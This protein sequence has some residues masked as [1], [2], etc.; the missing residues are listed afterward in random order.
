MTED[1]AKSKLTLSGKK[2]LTLKNLSDA[3][4]AGDGKK[5]V[6]VEVRKKRVINPAAPAGKEVKIDEATAAKLKLIAEAKEHEARRQQEE[7]EKAALR[8]KQKEEE[9]RLKE[10]EEQKRREEEERL[11]KEK[12]EK[13]RQAA[14]KEKGRTE[15]AEDE[16]DFKNK[17]KERRD[18]DFDD[19][20]D[21]DDRAKKARPTT[22]KGKSK[23]EV[24]E[25][26]RKKITKRSFEPQRRNP[27]VNIH[28][29]GGSDDDDD[30]YGYA[31]PRRRFKKKQPKP[32][33]VVQ[34][35]EKIIKEVIIPEVIT[36]QELANR[37]AEKGAEVIKKLMSL[38]VMA[39]INQPIDA[40]TAQ[41]IVEE[42][43]HKWK[44][45]ADSDVEMVLNEEQSKPENMLPRAPVSWDT[46][47]TA[48]PRF[49]TP[50]AKPTSPPRKPA[51]SPSI[52]A[53]TR[54]RSATGRRSPSLIPRDTK[55]F[56]KCAP[57]APR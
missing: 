7:E 27:K 33:P 8:Q 9:A 29:F 41:I 54:L 1:N 40:D 53:L 15:K 3:R 10:L 19:E 2:T 49:W 25:Q 56:P 34:P 44:R 55:R 47:T 57:A 14:E 31:A 43:G 28:T 35:Q 22:E 42:M 11:E 37:M 36:V 20:D 21:E 26:E 24:F 17:E 16:R 32:A 50:C 46:S 45:V 39:T 23:E 38:G 12:A 13:A 18:F 48:R 30:D 5:V 6:Q 51:A 52:S 4:P